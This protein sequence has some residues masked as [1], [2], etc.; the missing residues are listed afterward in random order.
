MS[1][2]STGPPA[3]ADP[4]PGTLDLRALEQAM[5]QLPEAVIL[6]DA[7]SGRRA[8]ANARARDLFP[9]RPGQAGPLLRL[10]RP[11]GPAIARDAF[12]GARSLL[13][14]TIRGELFEAESA[15]GGDR[16]LI[17]VQARPLRDEG[18]RIYAAVVVFEDVTARERARAERDALFAQ[19]H[20]AQ[21]S[22]EQSEQD[23]RGLA[24]SIP[25][26]VWAMRD[27][28]IDFLNRRF[29]DYTGIDLERAAREG[30]DQ[31]VHPEDLPAAQ[32]VRDVG[33]AR[34]EAFTTEYRLRGRDGSY[35]WFLARSVPTRDAGGK[36]VRWFGTATDID[37]QKR[38][39]Q[40]SAFLSAASKRLSSSLDY[41]ETLGS[42][43]QLAVPDFADWATVDLLGP[44][45]AIRRVAVAHVDPEKTSLGWEFSRKFPSE[46]QSPG[47]VGKV[48]RTG[49]PE[50]VPTITDE[51][52]VKGVG[53]PEKLKVVLPLRFRSLI[54]APMTL[55][56]RVLGAVTFV[57]AESGRHYSERDLELAVEVGRRAAVA[58][59]NARLFRDSEAANRAK[60]ELLATVSHELR[61]PLTAVLGYTRMLRSGTLPEER[62]AKA[63]EVI[64]RNV[65]LQAQLVEDLLDISRIVSGKL[66]LHLDRVELADV[67]SAA[68]AVVRPAAEAKGIAL[69]AKVAP[70]SNAVRGDFD[71]LQQ[72]AWNLLSNAIKF[73]A[74]GGNVELS[75]RR[76]EDQVELVVADTGEGIA[77]T[78]LPYL[79][80]RFWQADPS[81][82]R[83]HGGLGL[84]LAIVRHLVELHG[85]TV[86]ARSEGV[87]KGA[88]FTVSLPAFGQQ[89]R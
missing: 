60:D 74:S 26:F 23:F 89:A 48:V 39:A 80:E 72:V 61:T 36:R 31:V 7:A 52:M 33:R 53:D 1:A 40:R 28:R 6:V 24:E 25:Q 79:F 19:A 59:E 70:G 20:A 32:R 44:E 49:E 29:I 77:P 11:G 56:G 8:W 3:H 58:V 38:A 81:S 16:S 71:R 87:G 84:G 76:A 68:L 54:T 41:E 13:G 55:H 5:E 51:M 34:E 78:A 18:G 12:P 47:G 85:G 57:Q 35:R 30:L 50:L 82:T 15:A 4:Q 69:T 75:V 66:R 64:D 73:T 22:A 27:G 88:V 10:W 45:G 62:R 21:A 14:E 43:A 17:S 65:R 37:E 83:A 63:L 86:A 42:V 46:L 9:Q 2:R 67:V